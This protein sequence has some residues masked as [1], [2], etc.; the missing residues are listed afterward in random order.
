[1]AGPSSQHFPGVE[2]SPMFF[3]LPGFTT[4]SV[5]TGGVFRLVIL[6]LVAL[7]LGT[8]HVLGRRRWIVGLSLISD[9]P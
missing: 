5:L 9:V 2:V 7:Q 1:M 4:L 6:G 3:L 8:L